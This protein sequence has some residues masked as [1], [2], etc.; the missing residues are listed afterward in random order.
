MDSS[1]LTKITVTGVL[2]VLL[3]F[4]FSKY[5][6]K[7]SFKQHDEI[8]EKALV[9]FGVVKALNGAVSLVQGTYLD[10]TPAGVGVSLSVGEVLDPV[11]D[12]IERFSWVMLLS[13]TSLAIQRVIMEIGGWWP[14]NLLLVTAIA[15]FLLQLWMQRFH[16]KEL[17]NLTYKVMLLMLVF[18]FV[19]P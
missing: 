12:L 5:L 1:R 8:L 9:T 4:S 16:N 10:I 15:Y 11:N 13:A 2:S 3:V 19:M 17:I 7:Q 14:V 6:D 18:R